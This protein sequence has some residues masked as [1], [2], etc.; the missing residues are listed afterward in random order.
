MSASRVTWA[1]QRG[2]QLEHR[3]N[4]SPVGSSRRTP[5]RTKPSRPIASA[6]MQMAVKNRYFAALKRIRLALEQCK[7]DI[8]ELQKR[9]ERLSKEEKIVSKK[10]QFKFNNG[11]KVVL[12]HMMR[13]NSSL[14]ENKK[15]LKDKKILFRQLNDKKTALNYAI[16]QSPY[17]ALPPM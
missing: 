8:E 10:L 1:N 12:N 3:R 4:I 17:T 2:R 6:T 7:K 9:C 14:K 13:I 16:R 11:N 15:M 5:S